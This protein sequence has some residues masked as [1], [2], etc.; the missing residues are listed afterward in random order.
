MQP[1]L[2]I[3]AILFNSDRRSRNQEL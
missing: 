3:L 2:Q 1:D